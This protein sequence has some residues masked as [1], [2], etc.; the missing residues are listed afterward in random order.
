MRSLIAAGQ[1][2]IGNHTWSHSNLVAMSDGGIRRD[3]ERNEAWIEKTFGI[4]A[5]PWFR[6]PF[7][8]RSSRTDAVAGELGYTRILLWD[9]TFGDS[10]LLTPRVLLEQARKYLQPGV[11]ML[12]HANHP[13]AVQIFDRIQALLTERHLEPVTLDEMFG[14]SR[15]TG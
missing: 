11:V 9:G 12:G 1:V 7:G 6:P 2:Q 13:T 8:F 3:I 15:Q 5:R 10:Q 4:T 14:T